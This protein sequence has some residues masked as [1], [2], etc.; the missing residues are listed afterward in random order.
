MK[1][2]KSLIR[3]WI[4]SASVAGF[5]G[6]WAFLAHAG[7]PAPL[8]SASPAAMQLSPLPTLKPL[9]PLEGFASNLQSLPLM[10]QTRSGRSFPLLR[11]SGS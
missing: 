6:G 2:L 9:P 11:T 10:P 4:A 5:V 1:P 8:T 7:K 3:V